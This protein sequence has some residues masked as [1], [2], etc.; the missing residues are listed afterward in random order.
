MLIDRINATANIEVLFEA[1]VIALTASHE[2]RL[3]RVR[4]KNRKTGDPAW[5][6]TSAA[7]KH[8][9]PANSS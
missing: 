6:T 5:S 7:S 2:G 8:Y 3:D 1:E 4:W 9:R